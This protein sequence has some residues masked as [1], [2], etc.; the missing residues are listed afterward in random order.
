MSAMASVMTEICCCMIHVPSY[1]RRGSARA[2]SRG[3]R[4][5]AHPSGLPQAETAEAPG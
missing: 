1:R 5:L 4:V 3:A 2:R